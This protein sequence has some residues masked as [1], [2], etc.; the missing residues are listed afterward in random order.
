MCC[1]ADILKHIS[2]RVFL[3][4]TSCLLKPLTTS[5]TTTTSPP[6]L[7]AAFKQ[8][9]EEAQVTQTGQSNVSAGRGGVSAGRGGSG[10]A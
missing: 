1:I 8:K 7:E 3:F 9:K 10:I 4:L 2:K 5:P 6:Q